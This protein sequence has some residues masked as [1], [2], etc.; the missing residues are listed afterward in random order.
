MQPG[1]ATIAL[2]ELSLR[3]GETTILTVDVE[4][5][6]LLLGGHRYYVAVEEGQAEVQVRRVAG[7][8]MVKLRLRATVYGPC[9]RCLR[10]V[11]LPVEAEQEEFVPQ[12]PQSWDD[13]VSPFVQDLVVDAAGLAREAVVLG[14]PD[15]IL[16]SEDC[17]GICPRC[18]TDLSV[19][20]CS[21]P[22]EELD[23][24]WAKL[25]ELV[26]RPPGED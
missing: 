12:E 23:P 16:C 11:V 20:G 2:R 6:P 10:E 14:L 18:G 22:P 4:M 1:D 9:Y 19:A 15:K 25:Q 26:E 3:G 8:Y 21:C 5:A 13:E 24:R 7:G 17:P